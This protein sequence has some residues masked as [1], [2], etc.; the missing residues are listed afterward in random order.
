MRGAAE[1][2][3]KAYTVVALAGIDCAPTSIVRGAR[4][5]S[6]AGERSSAMDIL[7]WIVFGLV[8]GLVAK[9]ITG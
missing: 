8:V 4:Y 9:L 3:S 7:L 1:T 2:K 6:C 5:R